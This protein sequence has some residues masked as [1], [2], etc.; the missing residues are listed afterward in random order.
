MID[1]KEQFKTLTG[2]AWPEIR[3]TLDAAAA[4]AEP[5]TLSYFR[6]QMTVENKRPA[7]FDP[8]TEADRGAES[9]IRAVIANDFPEHAIVGEEHEPVNHGSDFSWIIDPIDGT[10]A[11]ISGVPLWGTLIGFAHRG[12]VLAGIMS[13]PFIGETF[14]GGPEGSF[15]R[16]ADRTERL[17][18]SGCTT[19]GA[20]RLFTTTPDLFDTGERQAAWSALTESS[21]LTRYGCDCYAYSLLAAGHVDLV[22]EPKLNVY[23]IA[24]LIPIIEQAGGVLARWDG[25]P[26]DSGGDVVAAATPELLDQALAAIAE[27]QDRR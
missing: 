8:V 7:D 10:R 12:R 11:F 14:I 1:N 2:L 17:A 16:R 6:Q 5:Q 26:A 15:Y 21:L 3:A 24:A 27:A 13:Q 19:I 23:D 25:G 9:A 4:S 20:A 22:V 18:T